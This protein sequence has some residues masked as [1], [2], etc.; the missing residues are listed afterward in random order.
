MNIE[1]KPEK[2]VGQIKRE[3]SSAYPF[4]K[5]EVSTCRKS[6]GHCVD[7]CIAGDLK[8]LSEIQPRLAGGFINIDKNVTVKEFEAVFFDRF[9]LSVQV[10]RRS[11][12]LWLETTVTDSWT[13][14]QQ[15]SHAK[16]SCENKNPAEKLE[17][18][19]ELTRDAD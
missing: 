11:G 9:S 2:T 3:L 8:L 15:N 6:P 18:D 10:F 19:Y 17:K 14:D 5:F 12:K 16:H 7:K 13:L 4:L 1:I